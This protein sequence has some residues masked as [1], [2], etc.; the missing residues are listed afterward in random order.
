MIGNIDTVV[1]THAVK[2][3]CVCVGLAGVCAY[4]RAV[5]LQTGGGGI[6]GKKSAGALR[7]R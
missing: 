1:D 3:G 7:I 6:H 4:G 2:I 5:A